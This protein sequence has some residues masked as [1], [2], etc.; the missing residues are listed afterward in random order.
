MPLGRKLKGPAYSILAALLA[1]PA[2]ACKNLCPSA[3]KHFRVF[4]GLLQRREHAELRSDWYGQIHMQ[5][6]Y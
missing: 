6:V 4:N 5:S 3:L 1:R 2:M